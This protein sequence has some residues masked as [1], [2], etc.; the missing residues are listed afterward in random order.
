M[1]TVDTKKVQAVFDT[2]VTLL[3]ISLNELKASLL[4]ESN[5]VTADSLDYS[6]QVF[7]QIV[8]CEIELRKYLNAAGIREKSEKIKSLIYI[9]VESLESLVELESAD[10]SLTDTI[11]DTIRD[12]IEV[13]KLSCPDKT[14]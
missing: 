7:V 1:S 10:Y 13:I 11:R 4:L 6:L 3:E 2:V 14:C 9:L 8:N 12:T 5:Q